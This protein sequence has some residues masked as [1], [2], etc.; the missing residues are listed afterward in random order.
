M[1]DSSTSKV[2]ISY[3][4]DD[5]SY[6]DRL[7][8][9]LRPHVR[10]GALPV[11]VDRQIKAGDEWKKEIE[12][13]LDAAQI[14]ILLVS[15][16]F[17]ASDFV[18]EEELPKLLKGAEER[19]VVIL[20]VIL[21]PCLSSLR[22]SSLYKYQAINDP[23]QP[24][25]LMPEGERDVIWDRLVERVLEAL[26]TQQARPLSPPRQKEPSLPVSP[27]RLSQSKV[28]LT[29][30][31]EQYRIAG[32]FYEARDCYEQ[33]LEQ[34]ARYLPAL[35]GRAL[36]L[37]HISPMD[38]LAAA[39][40]I[41]EYYPEN[42]TTYYTKG[43]ILKDMGRQEEAVDVFNQAIALDGHYGEAHA[44]KV[45]VLADQGKYAEA[46]AALERALDQ[47]PKD[48]A[49]QQA[50]QSLNR[51][52]PLGTLLCTLKGHTDWVESVAWSKK[53]HL[54]SAGSDNTVRLWDVASGQSL[55]TLEGHS[56]YVREVAW[57]PDGRFLAS[58]GDDWT[59]RVW[60]ITGSQPPRIL[61]CHT[62]AVWGIA[63]SPDGR[64]LASVGDDWALRLW[65]ATDCRCISVFPGHTDRVLMVAW[66]PDGR[67]LASASWDQ[68]VRLWPAAGGRRAILD[69]HTDKVLAVAWSP[70]CRRLA[71][72]STDKTVRI[73]DVERYSLL[74]TLRGHTNSVVK[75]AWSRDGR[76]ASASHDGT[77]RIWD[78]TK[79][80]RLVT[81]TGH[82]GSVLSVAWSPDGRRIASSGNDG[83]VRLWDAVSG[84]LLATLK[85]KDEHLPAED[86]ADAAEN[87]PAE[88]EE[89]RPKNVLT[90]AWSPIGY[91]LASA[92]EDGSVRVW[93]VGDGL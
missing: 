28:L 73:W 66:S 79:G 92:G 59:V 20:Q 8:K 41:I 91:R 81:L 53:G 62:G 42:V 85:D 44:A 11:W 34:D 30:E 70:D 6:L 7:Q 24:L 65:D 80:R 64:R 93:W 16:S 51:H 36:V 76:L 2:F 63:W 40:E 15:V 27:S 1:A 50:L 22:R 9:H 18:A 17:L 78:A 75:V 52:L 32:R 4:H 57:S 82:S 47:N 89:E 25:S 55:A 35:R 23:S 48:V 39:N 26:N 83:T 38:A 5:E 29:E 58:A 14:A 61:V 67:Y 10:S 77:I 21:T 72:A 46:A 19:G 12:T 90:V 31:G 84:Q 43:Q 33:A 3:S 45:Q 49:I 88:D 56:N 54:A 13:A 86:A 37:L 60:D 71:S 68:T 69:K 74:A 87:V